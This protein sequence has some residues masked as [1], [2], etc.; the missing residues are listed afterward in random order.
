M[1]IIHCAHDTFDVMLQLL[2]IIIIDEHVLFANKLTPR[3]GW[4]AIN[5]NDDAVPSNSIVLFNY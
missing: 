2:H 1:I 4:T 5:E 3:I